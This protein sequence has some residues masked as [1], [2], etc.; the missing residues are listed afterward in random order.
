LWGTFAA[1][2]PVLFFR[3]SKGLWLAF[4]YLLSGRREA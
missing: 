3:Y 1:I 2:F 4:G